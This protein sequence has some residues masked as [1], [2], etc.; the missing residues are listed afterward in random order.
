MS[1]LGYRA[2]RNVI[3][4]QL[5]LPTQGSSGG[6]LIGGDAGLYRSG[7]NQLALQSGDDLWI[8]GANKLIIRDAGIYIHSP[9]DGML[10]IVSD[11]DL[12]LN[13]GNIFIPGYLY[14]HGDTDTWIRFETNKI[15]IDAGGTR[16][17]VG[18]ITGISF[19][20]KATTAQPAHLADP[21]DLATCIT[22]ITQ[23]IDDQK[24]LG[25]MAA[26]P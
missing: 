4:G 23:L 14:H 3:Q 17:Y 19:Y 12:L 10:D 8:Q 26:D 22:A 9:S 5:K 13:C 15:T 11:L 16:G 25:L 6:I 18:D 1:G 20:G 24:A 7:S 21:T 2:S